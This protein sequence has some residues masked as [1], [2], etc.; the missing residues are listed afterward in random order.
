MLKK[1]SG[2]VERE[3]KT[4]CKKKS[5]E[6]DAQWGVNASC[7]VCGLLYHS[8]SPFFFRVLVQE[9][10]ADFNRRTFFVSVSPSVSHHILASVPN[11]IRIANLQIHGSL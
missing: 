8:E 4:V 3:V 6:C 7:M 1:R 10:Q 2:S 5:Q 9:Q 11:G